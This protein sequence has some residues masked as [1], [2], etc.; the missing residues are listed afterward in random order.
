MQSFIELHQ[1][2]LSRIETTTTTIN[3]L[4]QFHIAD[5]V[6]SSGANVTCRQ[7]VGIFY[8]T[9]W[10]SSLL[11]C[12]TKSHSCGGKTCRGR[13]PGMPY[14]YSVSP[15]SPQKTI[16]LYTRFT[17]PRS[18]SSDTTLSARI[19]YEENTFMSTMSRCAF[20][21]PN[22]FLMSFDELESL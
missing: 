14:P 5:R 11:Q 22:I 3:I 19:I 9:L 6:A 7:P 21:K 15:P 2:H 16:A 18:R 13:Y 17:P 4:G 1:V 12:A 8:Y 20:S 10:K